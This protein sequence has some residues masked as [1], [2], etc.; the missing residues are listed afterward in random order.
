MMI[1]QRCPR[2]DELRNDIDVLAGY[3]TDVPDID[4]AR[5]DVTKNDVRDVEMRSYPMFY[6]Y[7]AGEEQSHK[8]YDKEADIAVW[9]HD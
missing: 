2:C 7:P 8:M 4:V 5:I 1:D 9:M 3:F 6:F